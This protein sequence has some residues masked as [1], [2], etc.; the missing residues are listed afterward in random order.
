MR[1]YILSVASF[2][3]VSCDEPDAVANVA[4]NQETSQEDSNKPT[5]EDKPTSSGETPP[6][7]APLPESVTPL[8]SSPAIQPSRPTKYPTA[9]GIPGK[10]GFVYNPYTNRPVDTRGMPPSSLVMDPNDPDKTHRF[11]TPGK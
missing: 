9:V 11:R 7:T 10:P 6:Q 4:E 5:I 8:T 3:L 2:V 1:T